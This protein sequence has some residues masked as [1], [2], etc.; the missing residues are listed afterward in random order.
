MERTRHGIEVV[1]SGMVRMTFDPLGPRMDTLQSLGEVPDQRAWGP[2]Q[3]GHEVDD[4]D[5]SGFQCFCCACPGCLGTASP[6]P[7]P[8]TPGTVK[9]HS[10]MHNVIS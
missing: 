4:G 8:M 7:H 5:V 10:Q 6:A 1:W 3:T 9:P 2:P